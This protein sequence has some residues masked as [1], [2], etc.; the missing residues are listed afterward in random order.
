MELCTRDLG[1]D[2]GKLAADAEC[3]GLRTIYTGLQMPASKAVLRRDFP[4]EHPAS[5][6]QARACSIFMHCCD[7]Y[8]SCA[9]PLK[10]LASYWTERISLS[11]LFMLDCDR[12]RHAEPVIN[13]YQT[14]AC[15]CKQSVFHSWSLKRFGSQETDWSIASLRGAGVHFWSS[16]SGPKEERPWDFSYGSRLD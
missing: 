7:R 15:Q 4:C 9:T 13:S 1:Q 5:V 14:P 11:P 12:N 3:P 8:R 2:A 6:P 10:R 16:G